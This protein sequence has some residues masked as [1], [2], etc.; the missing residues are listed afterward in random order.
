MAPFHTTDPHAHIPTVCWGLDFVKPTAEGIDHF[1]YRVAP[2]NVVFYA[3]D[4]SHNAAAWRR[5]EDFLFTSR[6]NDEV[7][8][9][10][11]ATHICTYVRTDWCTR[12]D[13][14]T[15]RPI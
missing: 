11:F 5:K 10:I 2:G 15:F 7:S 14:T 8:E 3:S 4:M 9:G 1:D 6:S 12:T 13:N